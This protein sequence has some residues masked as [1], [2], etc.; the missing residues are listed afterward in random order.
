[1]SAVS[2]MSLIATGMP[3]IGDSGLPR[4]PARGRGVGGLD[5]AVLVQPDEGADGRIELDDALEGFLEIGAGRGLAGAQ[6]RP[7]ARHSLEACLPLMAAPPAFPSSSLARATSGKAP[8][9][10]TP[11]RHRHRAPRA[12]RSCSCAAAAAM[13]RGSAIPA[14]RSDSRSDGACGTVLPARCLPQLSSWHCAQDRLSWPWRWLNACA[15]LVD[16]RLERRVVVRGDRLAARLHA[17]HRPSAPASPCSRRRSGGACWFCTRHRLMRCSRST[18]RPEAASIGRIAR[19]D[20]L[21]A[22]LGVAVA[23]GAG[24]A[25][26]AGLG[27]PQRLAV[28]HRQH[29]G[30]AGVVVLH[31]LV[32]AAHV[33]VGR[34]ALVRA[35]CQRPSEGRARGSHAAAAS[36]R[37]RRLIRR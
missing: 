37:A 34:A 1:M 16:E 36:R 9:R 35:G 22:G 21:H 19:R 13:S 27:A 32:V 6:A 28:E 33:L 15:A 29:A 23:V 14:G 31:R 3:S 25:G 5:G 30:I 24:F 4:L 18:G 26:A 7:P 17:R 12:S 10:H 2:M 20:A 8:G 11:A